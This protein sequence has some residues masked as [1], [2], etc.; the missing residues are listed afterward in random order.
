MPPCKIALAWKCQGEF[1][2]YFCNKTKEQETDRH[3]E[4]DTEGQ[5]YTVGSTLSF[6][7]G[8][9]RDSFTV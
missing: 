3:R 7:P 4:V 5:V 1:L 2:S 6:L 8:A 9:R